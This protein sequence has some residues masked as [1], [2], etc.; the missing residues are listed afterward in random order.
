MWLTEWES[1]ADAPADQT[2]PG[3]GD[4]IMSASPTPPS[5]KYA[6][7]L[8]QEISRADFPA[9]FGVLNPSVGVATI[10][11][12]TVGVVTAASHELVA[13][14]RV[15]LT[16]TGAMPSG[17]IANT[18][19]WVATTPTLSTLTLAATEGGPSIALSGTQ[20][21]TH[22]LRRSPYGLGD[23]VSTFR[24]PD[25]GGRVPIGSGA[26][27]GLTS[28][29]VGQQIGAE[30]HPLKIAEMPPHSH[31]PS[32]AANVAHDGFAGSPASLTAGGAALRMGPLT[33]QGGGAAH[34]NMQ[35]SI[36]VSYYI[37]VRP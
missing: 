37:R 32:G 21:G 31:T 6:R 14:D 4:I 19:Y 26:G 2:W 25:L 35:P 20:S 30:T 5:D 7:P 8:G 18:R 36:A 10:A 27:T 34:N 1:Q 15:W 13:G 28:R 3:V 29:P 17:L 12:G 23:G 16:T 9:A 11:I 22:T 33:A 24:L